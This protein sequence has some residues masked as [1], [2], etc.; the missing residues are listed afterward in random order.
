VSKE[1]LKVKVADFGISGVAD[2]FNPDFDMGTLKYMAPEVLS[3]KERINTPGVD[4]WACGVILYYLL[5]G[6]LPFTGLSNSNITQAIIKG[7]FIFPPRPTVN[8]TAK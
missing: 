7:S 2:S 5:F 4:I 1:D 6:Q 8:P 3:R